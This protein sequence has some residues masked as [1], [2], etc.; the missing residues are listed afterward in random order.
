[1]SERELATRVERNGVSETGV[2]GFE[3]QSHDP[4]RFARGGAVEGFD[5]SGVRRDRTMA[6]ELEPIG[7]GEAVQT[8]LRE[9]RPEVVSSTL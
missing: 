5:T 1:M 4:A 3:P 9:R 8:Y 7:L 6:D 2:A